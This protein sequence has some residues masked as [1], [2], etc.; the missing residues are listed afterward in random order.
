LWAKCKAEN[1]ERCRM[2]LE[3]SMEFA[4]KKFMPEV[5]TKVEAVIS[6]FWVK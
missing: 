1:A 2:A 3:D 4:V 5:M 6:D